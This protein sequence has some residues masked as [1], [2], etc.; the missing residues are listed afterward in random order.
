M[1]QP[2]P[3]S[4]VSRGRPGLFDVNVAATHA[5]AKYSIGD[6]A[7]SFAEDMTNNVELIDGWSDR[8][9]PVVMVLSVPQDRVSD[10]S[11]DGV[12]SQQCHG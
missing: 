10:V 5:A 6:A 9:V 12:A 3:R 2:V 7:L 8:L 11:R 1:L 4:R